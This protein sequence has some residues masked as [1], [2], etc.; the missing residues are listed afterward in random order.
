MKKLRTVLA[1]LLVLGF[2]R[3]TLAESLIQS[4]DQCSAFWSAYL[5]VPTPYG[6]KLQL[7]AELENNTVIL[8]FEDDSLGNVVLYQAK[9]VLQDDVS[10][11]IKNG[12]I[13][14]AYSMNTPY[15]YIE[16][17]TVT[18]SRVNSLG[19]SEFEINPNKI[20]EDTFIDWYQ[21][22]DWTKTDIEIAFVPP[23]CKTCQHK[24]GFRINVLWQMHEIQP[25]TCKTD[26]FNPEQES[27][28]EP[29]LVSFAGYGISDET[30]HFKNI[31]QFID[32]TRFVNY[33]VENQCISELR[34]S[35]GP[36][37]LDQW[38]KYYNPTYK[39]LDKTPWH[40]LMFMPDFP[41]TTSYD[42]L[43]NNQSHALEFRFT[44][45]TNLD[46]RIYSSWIFLHRK[47]EINPEKSSVHPP[48]LDGRQRVSFTY[49]INSYGIEN[50]VH[51]A[52]SSFVKTFSFQFKDLFLSCIDFE[53]TKLGLFYSQDKR[54][55]DGF[56]APGRFHFRVLWNKYF[57]INTKIAKPD[58]YQLS[59]TA[60]RELTSRYERTNDS[61]DAELEEYRFAMLMKMFDSE[62]FFASII[63]NNQISMFQ[64][65]N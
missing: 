28:E 6:N 58:L 30:I 34:T 42:I 16:S 12:S 11:E 13:K 65:E 23:N 56:S 57:R 59:A 4:N 62:A 9:L 39:Y 8:Q 21:Y 46:L 60:S 7:S 2:S 53:E 3:V 35:K 47:C 44:T 41:K 64:S 38:F 18:F 61:N 43:Y 55:S 37:S 51:S 27:T 54:F 5:A 52:F 25:C 36:S 22:I 48:P 26:S 17:Y 50:D 24:N 29:E 31:L 15:E 45:E 32:Q 33:L 49:I 10:F 40:V 63:A 14:T 1:L 19:S 20:D